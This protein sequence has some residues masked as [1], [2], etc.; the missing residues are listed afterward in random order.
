LKEIYKTL[1]NN[2]TILLKRR[3]RSQKPGVR[4]KQFNVLFIVYLGGSM[5]EPEKTFENLLVWQIARKIL[6]EHSEF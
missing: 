6:P 3:I 5:R 2:Y 4:K 1:I